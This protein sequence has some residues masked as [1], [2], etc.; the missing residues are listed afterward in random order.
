MR[1]HGKKK[2]DVF[3]L[4][5]GFSKAAGA[6]LQA[7]IL[8]E[9]LN[10]DIQSLY[11][12][13]KEIFENNIIKIKKLLSEIMLIDIS[14]TENLIDLEDIYTPLDSCILNN[15]AFRN[16]SLDNVAKYR[17]ALDT[18]ISFYMKKSLDNGNLNNDFIF[19][20]TDY[21]IKEKENREDDFISIITT[22]WDIL[23]DNSFYR[24]I[25]RSSKKGVIDYCY[26]TT[27]YRTTDHFMPGLLAKGK[28]CFNVK[29]LK[30]HGSLNWLFC[31]RCERL[32]T[33][34]DKKISID[35]YLIKPK[36]RI[37]DRNFKNPHSSDG[38]AHLV[39]RLLMPTYI[40]DLNN[41]QIKLIWQN[42]GVELSEAERLIFIGYSFPTAD[43]ELRQLL[44]RNV[45]HDT[46]IEIVLR[47]PIKN[48]IERRYK[49]F[50]G[51][52]NIEFVAI[53]SS[54]YLER[55]RT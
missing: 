1:Q 13:E 24:S 51:R 42:A 6:P 46:K 44:S 12:K 47:K 29:I 28:G 3:I 22:N 17:G 49:S 40:K 55:Y 37:C 54:T 32:Y 5:A 48:D 31:P 2:K 33:T 34:F 11:G 27:P 52:R 35:E 21:I 30:L 8:R 38:G 36:C 25:N 39:N 15:N 23:L 26:Y 53:G 18:L 20:F 50:F 10:F 45:P 14:D 19:K 4:G 9:I 16:V 7:D 41:V 43:F